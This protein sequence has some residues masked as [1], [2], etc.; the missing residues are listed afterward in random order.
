MIHT[1]QRGWGLSDRFSPGDVAPLEVQVDDLIAVMDAAASRRAVV[2]A[3]TV[4]APA[5]ILLAAS[6]PERV[7]GLVLCDPF[8]AFYDTPDARRERVEQT[9]AP[10]VSGVR[11]RT[12]ASCSLT[13][14]SS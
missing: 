8:V 12:T 10:G 11:R 13:T 1:D 4:T 14:T 5:A 2:F 6:V 9:S 7:S 3:S